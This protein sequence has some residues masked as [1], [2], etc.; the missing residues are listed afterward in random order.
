[1]CFF[2]IY[3]GVIGFGWGCVVGWGVGVLL[4]VFFIF[5][6]FFVGF[7]WGGFFF[8]IDIRNIV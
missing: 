3:G 8:F 1:V 6:L 4:F 7:F 2:Y 5:L